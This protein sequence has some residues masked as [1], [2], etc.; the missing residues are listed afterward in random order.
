VSTVL[1]SGVGAVI[2]YGI[3]R[4]LKQGRAR[5]RVIGT[6]IHEHAVGQAWCDA[7]VKCPPAAS[8]DFAPFLLELIGTYEI[9]CVFS[10]FPQELA[11]LASLH[12]VLESQNARVV[13]NSV[14]AL[15][16]GA[17]KWKLAK[18]L[19]GGPLAI[20]TRLVTSDARFDDLASSLGC[21]FVVK[22]RA[23]SASRGFAIVSGA[24]DWRGVAS[25]ASMIAQALIGTADEEYTAAIY[26]DGE[27]SYTA[28]IVMRRWL[29]REGNTARAEV[30]SNDPF[31]D[32]LKSICVLSR[33]IGPTNLQ[34]RLDRGIP[35]LLEINPRIS[36]S[37]Y[38]RSLCGYNEALMALD[39]YVDGVLPGQPLVQ[40]RRLIRYA[41]DRIW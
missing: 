13:I 5:L 37:T 12:E 25:D 7:F 1:V 32:A 29:G 24:D 26:G 34:F 4:S 11:V 33:P 20:Q 19:D 6:D 17:D 16:L 2:G 22:P 18:A 14:G 38:M 30:V 35:Y 36:S 41:E 40:A 27:G 23:G 15:A 3:V 8:K 39:H 10:G 31:C 21:P 9:G 28:S